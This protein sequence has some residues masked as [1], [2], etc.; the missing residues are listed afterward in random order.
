[1]ETKEAKN[2]WIG[3]IVIALI[4][5]AYY[6]GTSSKNSTESIQNTQDTNAPV[7]TQEQPAKSTASV[8]LKSKCAADGQD[9][10][11]KFYN[12]F[13]QVK[14]VWADPQFHFNSR[15]NT[16]LVYIWWND[17]SIPVTSYWTS[18]NKYLNSTQ[19]VTN[20]NIVFDVYSN[21]AILQNST[22]KTY[23]NENGVKDEKDVLS[24]YPY[25]QNIPNSN[26]TTFSN[27]LNVLMSE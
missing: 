5:G 3:I 19:V 21:Q 1:M 7:T 9:F 12:Q 24:D 26:A 18:D 17:T 25:A 8:A 22:T 20:N 23:T 13:T 14:S 2:V 4:A 11:L 16:C 10:Y 27:Q 6:F 15:L